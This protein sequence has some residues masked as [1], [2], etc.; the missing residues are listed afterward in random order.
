MNH[1][2]TQFLEGW[3]KG[4]PEIP[5]SPRVAPDLG[6]II[7][8]LSSLVDPV[9]DH[10]IALFIARTARSYLL[11][12]QMLEAAGT[13]RFTELLN[14]G[15][16]KVHFIGRQDRYKRELADIIVNG[17]DVGVILVR[18]NLARYWPD[19]HEFWCN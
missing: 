19:G 4:Q 9:A 11:A 14:S 5:E 15:N 1:E 8:D 6:M 18:E 16:T 17:E 13:A 10:P 12:A 3:N 7:S 2:V